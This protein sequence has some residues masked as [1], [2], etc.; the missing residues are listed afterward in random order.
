LHSSQ[1]PNSRE[2]GPNAKKVIV[3][4]EL[5]QPQIERQEIERA[6][7]WQEGPAGSA[8]RDASH[9]VGQAPCEEPETGNCHWLEQGPQEGRESSVAE[10]E[11]QLT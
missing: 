9:E 5:K 2:D 7:V 8:H 1:R 4:E 10:I 6:Q 11:Q 3:A